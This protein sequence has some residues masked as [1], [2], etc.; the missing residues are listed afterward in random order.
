MVLIK[1]LMF[2]LSSDLKMVKVQL[3]INVKDQI[4]KFQIEN[5]NIYNILSSLAVL[6]E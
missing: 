5:I 4:L 1:N 6:K 2:I 3:T